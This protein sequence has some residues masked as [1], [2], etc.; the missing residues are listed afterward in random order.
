[1]PF[2]QKT[3][4][5]IEASGFYDSFEYWG[6]VDRNRKIQF[7]NSI[8]VLSVPSL[9]REPKGLYVLEALANGVPVVQPNHGSFPELI[10]A[11]GGGIL[12]ASSSANDIADAVLS[13]IQDPRRLKELG[14]NG[15]KV[16]HAKFSDDQM[17]QATVHL[18]NKF[19]SVV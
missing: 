6:E 13:L 12:A 9:Y 10:D 19:L 8:D 14:D 1:L 3:L 11:T 17:A 5:Q 4:K 18:Y 15:K 16:V 7:L 2:F